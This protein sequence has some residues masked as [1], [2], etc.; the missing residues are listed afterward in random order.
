MLDETLWNMIRV[1]EQPL[2]YRIGLQLWRFSEVIPVRFSG[3]KQLRCCQTGLWSC[4][5]RGGK[6]GNI[7]LQELS[8]HPGNGDLAV[9]AIKS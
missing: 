2:H 6:I 8:V 1:M 5:M 9:E 7:P 4:A 3:F